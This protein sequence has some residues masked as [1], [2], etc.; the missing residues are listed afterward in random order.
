LNRL[1]WSTA[2]GYTL[3][4]LEG[5][6]GGRKRCENAR[7]QLENEGWRSWRRGLAMRLPGRL[8]LLES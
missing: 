2:S 4:A 6:E 1:P 8:E 7:A 5:G 3:G